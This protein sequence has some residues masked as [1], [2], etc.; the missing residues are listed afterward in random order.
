MAIKF[1]TEKSKEAFSSFLKK[2]S[3]VGKSVADGVQ[4]GAAELSEKAGIVP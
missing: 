3:E 1:D 4:K 2:T